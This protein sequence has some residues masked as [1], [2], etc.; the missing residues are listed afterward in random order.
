MKAIAH[1]LK[2]ASLALFFPFIMQGCSFYMGF[3]AKS[4]PPSETRVTQSV[5]PNEGETVKTV[6]NQERS[7]RRPI[8]EDITGWAKRGGANLSR[9]S[10]YPSLIFALPVLAI[11][12]RP[13]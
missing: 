4:T 6:S 13:K 8:E 2:I 3:H 7:K 10:P 5:T 11:R 1:Y 9:F 12:H